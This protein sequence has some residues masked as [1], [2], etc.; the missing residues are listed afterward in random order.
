[1]GAK[2]Y[3]SDYPYPFKGWS[4]EET[5]AMWLRILN[6]RSELA[7]WTGRVKE[8]G[9]GPVADEMWQTY[10]RIAS[11]EIVRRQSDVNQPWL[12]LA[13]CSLARV[14]WIQIVGELRRREGGM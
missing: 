3:P 4:N 7:L 2:D 11:L 1:M 12:A 8:S 14:D 10:E 5:Q 6:T 9:A 13:S